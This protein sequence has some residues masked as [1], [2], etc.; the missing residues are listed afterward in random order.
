FVCGTRVK[1]TMVVKSDQGTRT[2]LLT[3]ISG[4]IGREVRFDSTNV[5]VPIPDADPGGASSSVLVSNITSLVGKVTVSLHIPHPF[6]ADLALSLIGPD[7]TTNVLSANH[8]GFG[9]D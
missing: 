1:L 5:P 9:K 6:A 4:F 7:G 2:N 8:G 3:L